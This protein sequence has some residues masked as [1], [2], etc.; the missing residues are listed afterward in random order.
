MP[1]KTRKAPAKKA[2][3]KA[4]AEGKPSNGPCFCGCGEIPTKKGSQFRPGHDARLR[5]KLLKLRRLEAKD[6]ADSTKKY[7]E[8]L[9]S[10]KGVNLDLAYKWLATA[11]NQ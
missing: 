5:G 10:L 3:P 4:K 2:A 11:H 6:D 8:V 7:K 1:T 9:A